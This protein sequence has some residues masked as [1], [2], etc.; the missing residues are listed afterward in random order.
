MLLELTATPACREVSRGAVLFRCSNRLDGN[1]TFT[2]IGSEES[3][4]CGAGLFCVVSEPL[5]EDDRTRTRTRTQDM[6][7]GVAHETLMWLRRN[8]VGAPPRYRPDG[9]RLLLTKHFQNHCQGMTSEDGQKCGHPSDEF[10][11]ERQLRSFN[12]CET[13]HRGYSMDARSVDNQ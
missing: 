10:G 7:N 11:Y 4:A 13:L 2:T 3:S 5:S 12:R 6:P 1:T 9:E 8:Q